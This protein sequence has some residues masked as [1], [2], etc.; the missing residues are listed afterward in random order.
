[1]VSV[2]HKVYTCNAKRLHDLVINYLYPRYCFICIDAYVDCDTALKARRWDKLSSRQL[3]NFKKELSS[4]ISFN[5]PHI[6]C[7]DDITK[8]HMH[9]IEAVYSGFGAT[10]TSLGL[11]LDQVIECSVCSPWP[12]AKMSFVVDLSCNSKLCIVVAEKCYQLVHIF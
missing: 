5:L 2:H 11:D 10:L 4:L 7:P 1:M 3:N 8:C 6:G 12:D 9:P